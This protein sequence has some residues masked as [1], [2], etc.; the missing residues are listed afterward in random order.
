MLA[1]S[2][3]SVL[4]GHTKIGPDT[5]SLTPVLLQPDFGCNTDWSL[6]QCQMI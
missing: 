3:H 4:H 1:V 2:I 5:K 6:E